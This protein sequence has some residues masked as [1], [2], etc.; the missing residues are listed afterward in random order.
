LL[1]LSGLAGI[2]YVDLEQVNLTGTGNNTLS[3]AAADVVSISTTSNRLLVLGNAG[4][5]VNAGTGW[6]QGADQTVGA[7][8][9][10]SYTQ[11]LATLLVDT[12]ITRNIAA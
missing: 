11:G 2:R 10:A 1:N 12:D 6:T 4:D 8:V 5:A 3:L 7:Q 9:Y